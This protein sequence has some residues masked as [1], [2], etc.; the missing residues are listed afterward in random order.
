VGQ[1]VLVRY[2]PHHPQQVELTDFFSQW[3]AILITALFALLGW[4]VL[5]AAFSRKTNS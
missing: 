1:R 3:G 5:R 2:H 4:V